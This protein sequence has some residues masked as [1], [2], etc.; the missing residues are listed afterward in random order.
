[1]LYP[2][3]PYHRV[4]HMTSPSPVWGSERRV[5]ICIAKM[6][7]VAKPLQIAEWLLWTACRQELSNAVSIGTTT[8]PLQL[9][10]PPYNMF[11]AMSVSAE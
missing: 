9:P 7:V 10:L 2:M 4:P 6:Q 8:D 5:K 1:M 11:A 3:V